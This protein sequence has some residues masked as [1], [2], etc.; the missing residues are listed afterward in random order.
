MRKSP[1]LAAALAA[2]LS[3]GFAGTAAA[4]TFKV[5][6]AHSFVNFEISHIGFSMLQGR[7]NKLEGK[8]TYDAAKPD[9]STIEVKV[10]TGSVDSNYGE[11]DKHLREKYLFTDKFPSASFKSTKFSES[12]DKATLEGELTL[13]GVTKPVKVDVQFIG[14]GND[15]WGAATLEWSIPS[16]P[17]EYNFAK[18]PMVTSRYPL[19]DLTH[20]ERTSELPHT[21]AGWDDASKQTGEHDMAPMHIETE[22]HTAKALGIPMPSSTIKPFFVALG[23]VLMFCG[24]L[25]MPK[26]MMVPAF[27]LMLGGSA[28][29]IGFLYAWLTTPL[30]DHH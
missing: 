22:T 25:F 7:F 17:P 13:H 10:D 18:I 1:L 14:A 27:A 6:P 15:P 19:W 20:P 24:L 29:W 21:Q 3:L 12:G 30:E 28:M 4:E 26:G 11:R 8:F 16:P 23:I 2:S 5:D 9:A